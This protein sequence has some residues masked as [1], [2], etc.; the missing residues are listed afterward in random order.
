MDFFSHKPMPSQ[1]KTTAQKVA[2]N[3]EWAKDCIDSLF[4]MILF[5]NQGLRQSKQ[6]KKINYDLYNGVL[7]QEDMERICN[8]HKIAGAT[9]PAEVK[10]YPLINP[11]INALKGEE[12]KRRFDW[13]VVVINPDAISE[14]Q[15]EQK[16][17][18]V[19]FI[20]KHVQ[21]EGY[22]EE[23]AAKALE[24]LQQYIK[25]EFRNLKELKSTRLLTYYTK[26]LDLKTLFN[27]GW[28]DGLLVGEELYCVEAI[29]G[30]PK[31]RKCNPLNTYFLTYPDSNYI[32]DC[33][34]ILEEGYVPIGDIIDDFY[35]DLSSTDIT[36]LETKGKST[37][38]TASTDVNYATNMIFSD[39]SLSNGQLIDTNMIGLGAYGGAFDTHGNVRKVKIKWRS[40]RE[41]GVLH[42]FDENGD[43]Q[44][45]D[46]DEN[47]IPNKNAGE[48]VKKIWIGEWWEG[49]KI[50]NHLYK[51]IKPSEIQFRK[52]DN[53][54]YCASGYVGS[55]YNTNSNRVQSLF[56]LMKP[57]NYQYNAY[58]YRT[59]LAFIKA[60]K[61][62]IGTLDIANIPDGW[63][64]DQ[65]MY[66]AEILGWAVKDSFKEGK[67]GQATGKLV[68]NNQQDTPVLNLELGN[69]VESHIKMLQYIENQLDKISGIAEQR[70]GQVET[71]AGLGTTQQA[72]E[73]SRTITEPWFAIHDNIKLRVMGALLETAK[74]CMRGK[75]KKI[76][77]I[78]DDASQIIDDIEGELINDAEYGLLVSNSSADTE[79]MKL[80][81]DMSQAG[82]QND[83]ISYSELI[84]IHMS[85]SISKVRMQIKEAEDKRVEMQQQAEKAEREHEQMLYEMQVQHEKELKEFEIQE[86]QKDRD[87]KQYEIDT[88]AATD[89]QKAEIMVYAKQ[90][91]IDQDNDG[92]PDPI[93][94][95]KLALNRQ[96]IE[97]KSF[98]EQVKIENDRKK[99]EADLKL[100]EK[101]L[102]DKKEIENKKIKAIEVQNKS[103]ELMQDK[104][105]KFKEKEI[106]FKEK[107]L[108]SKQIL[109]QLKIKAAKAKAVQAAKKKT[110]TKK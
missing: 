90:K 3:F 31:V 98:M 65:W 108:K 93:E 41:I 95:G 29:N 68:G 56:D 36:F 14:K 99:H 39:P 109:E 88:K 44:T 84:D 61:G 79:L 4:S 104:E 66:Y 20:N 106:K 40:L 69:Y 89:I 27:R 30:E 15:E 85:E 49:Y 19:E 37:Q 45:R 55:L 50:A 21:S 43:E 83:K 72:V 2:K 96:D 47:Y 1:K 8:P 86:N 22:S 78:L 82:I 7:N 63:S 42:Y 70:Q 77:Y 32:E 76:Q 101:E 46:V 103:Q 91:N 35:D 13:K 53:K 64:I 38:S 23:E 105:L 71:S 80:L 5:Q 12:T 18:F 28:E 51:K 75:S 48:W 107:E 54:S 16:Q 33:D 34:A 17:Q 67:K 9:F 81:K 59:E 87:L 102:T 52:L 62:K 94:I 110:T 74:F 73:A 97:S 92:I 57:Y 100:K 11:K 6:N 26:Y 10:H 25:Y 24:K 58:M 60:S